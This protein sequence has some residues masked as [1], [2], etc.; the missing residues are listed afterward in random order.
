MPVMKLLL[1]VTVWKS[2]I[3]LMDISTQLRLGFNETV[4]A[5]TNMLEEFF[6]SIHKNAWVVLSI[7]FSFQYFLKE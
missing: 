6:L 7:V 3:H 5:Q 1:S 4:T 2:L